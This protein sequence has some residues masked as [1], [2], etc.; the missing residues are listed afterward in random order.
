[1]RDFSCTDESAGFLQPLMKAKIGVDRENMELLLED[2]GH[3]ETHMR[4]HLF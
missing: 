2:V 1:M 4:S 3:T